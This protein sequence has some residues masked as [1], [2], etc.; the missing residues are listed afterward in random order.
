MNLLPTEEQQEIIAVIR[1]FLANEV[2]VRRYQDN[3]NRGAPYSDPLWQQLV[4]LGW[5]GIGVAEEAGGMGLSMAEEVL[6]AREA[7]R[8]LVSPTVLGTSFAAH[9]AAE[10]GNT[11]VA[12]A[13]ISGA[14]RA[15]LAVASEVQLVSG[16]VSASLTVFD[17][18]GADYVVVVDRHQCLL[19]AAGDLD[20]RCRESCTDEALAME[21][22]R[23]TTAS[24]VA[25]SAS[26][27]SRQRF[28]LFIA[29]ALAGIAEAARDDAASYARERHQFGQA[30]GSFQA[31]AHLCADMAVSAEAAW[32]QCVYAALELVE[33]YGSAP[34]AV[35]SAAV[36]SEKAALGNAR[37]NVQVHGGVGFTVEF[38]AHY[39]VKRAHVYRQL[40][41]QAVDTLGTLIPRH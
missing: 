30:I 7:G 25:G 38:D 29:A 28:V 39:F 1:A 26:A 34:A 35:A 8:Q 41:S 11:A 22:A 15:A 32:A 20:P 19:I 9:L 12:Q 31:I 2:S 17:G 27:A 6:I 23:V 5:F 13:L 40:M 36:I 33:G 4:A 14:A 10:A 37:D 3:A 18:L 21:L 16:R 24:P